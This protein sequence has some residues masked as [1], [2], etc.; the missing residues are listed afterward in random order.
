VVLNDVFHPSSV[1]GT[2]AHVNVDKLQ[3]EN[4]R[5]LSVQAKWCLEDYCALEPPPRVSHAAGII[6]ST[7]YNHLCFFFSLRVVECATLPE[8]RL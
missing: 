7:I 3:K 1:P 8:Y 2:V 5:H 4:T 6:R